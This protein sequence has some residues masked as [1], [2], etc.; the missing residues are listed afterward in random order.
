MTTLDERVARAINE[1]DVPIRMIADAV[2]V[3]VQAII[4]VAQWKG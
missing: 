2:G 4:R 1:S 3:T